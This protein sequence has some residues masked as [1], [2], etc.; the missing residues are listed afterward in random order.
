MLNEV[1][2]KPEEE[3]AQSWI[4]EEKN[5]LTPDLLLTSQLN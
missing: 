4:G 2:R 3:V 1:C 5:L